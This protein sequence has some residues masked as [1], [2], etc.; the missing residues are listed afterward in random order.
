MERPANKDLNNL[1]NMKQDL[2]NS[3]PLNMMRKLN[4]FMDN[5]VMRAGGQLRNSELEYDTKHPMILPPDHSVTK[6]IISELHE[7]LRHSGVSHVLN[8]SRRHYW[9]IRGR[10]AVRKVLAACFKCRVWSA[11]FGSNAWR[12]RPRHELLPEKDRSIAPELI[13]WVLWW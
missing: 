6:M 8:T 5:G 2:N 4:P 12:I 1:K 11:S 10:A 7:E 13:R 3:L 9:I